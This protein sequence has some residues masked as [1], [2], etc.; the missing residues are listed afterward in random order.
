MNTDANH[1]PCLVAVA[2]HGSLDDCVY[3]SS[4]NSIYVELCLIHVYSS[5]SAVTKTML[6]LVRAQV[7]VQ[8]RV[9]VQAQVPVMPQEL[10]VLPEMRQELPVMPQELLVLLA[11]PH[12]LPLLQQVRV[13]P[14]LEKALV[15][16]LVQGRAQ[17]QERAVAR[18]VVVVACVWVTVNP[19]LGVTTR[20]RDVTL[21]LRSP[22]CCLG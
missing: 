10:P 19:A 11:M 21:R 12:R 16:G 14:R 2:Q 13:P 18:R 15:Q 6:S 9:Q 1:T 20:L 5:L 17:A 8:A 3:V 4:D 22:V 7:Q